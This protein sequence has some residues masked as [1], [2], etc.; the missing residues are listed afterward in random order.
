MLRNILVTVRAAIA[1]ENLSGG[2]NIQMLVTRPRA[3][4]NKT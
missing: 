4:P 1:A 3:K 2:I